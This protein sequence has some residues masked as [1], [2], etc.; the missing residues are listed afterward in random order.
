MKRALLF[1]TLVLGCL[2]GYSQDEITNSYASRAV[3]D[4][5]G[6][7]VSFLEPS[8]PLGDGDRGFQRVRLLMIQWGGMTYLEKLPHGLVRDIGAQV[9]DL[10]K[11]PAVVLNVFLQTTDQS[12]YEYLK[13]FRLADSIAGFSD[14]P[15][16]P[17]GG[18]TL[19]VGDADG[20][21]WKTLKVDVGKAGAPA[22]FGEGDRVLYMRYDAASG[23][24][25]T[26]DYTA[27]FARKVIEQEYQPDRILYL[28]NDDKVNLRKSPGTDAAIITTLRK[29]T[30]FDIVD[31]TENQQTIGGKTARWYRILL[32][33]GKSGGWIFGAFIKGKP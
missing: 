19:V 27:G 23:R 15:A 31:R 26:E 22:E 14:S 32:D 24:Y 20:T 28:L 8:A 17:S 5:G 12:G 2:S 11:S 13:L 18:F 29:D 30:L 1:V 16:P 7:R 33:D 21:G 9:V 3:A 10:G 6:V 4:S 25:A